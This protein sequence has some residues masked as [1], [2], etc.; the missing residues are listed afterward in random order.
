MFP[1]VIM[2]SNKERNPS[3]RWD[4]G[5]G[6]DTG[7][8]ESS[9]ANRSEGAIAEA[10]EEDELDRLIADDGDDANGKRNWKFFIKDSDG[11]F[12]KEFN[13][14]KSMMT[15]DSFSLFLSSSTSNPFPVPPPLSNF[16]IDE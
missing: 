15:N 10:S 9:L 3:E 11:K 7:V 13:D 4:D 5:D 12:T 6:D 2:S 16:L 1:D 8:K 14:F